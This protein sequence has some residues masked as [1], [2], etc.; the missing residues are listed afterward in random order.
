MCVMEMNGP[1][2]H[3]TAHPA[4]RMLGWREF[5]PHFHCPMTFDQ[6]RCSLV[7]VWHQDTRVR[8]RILALHLILLYVL[9]LR[10]YLALQLLQWG[11]WY[12]V[13]PEGAATVFLSK[14]FVHSLGG[15]N[16][17]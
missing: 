11:H 15:T 16:V 9:L 8:G 7:L 13:V 2:K 12:L 4:S 1:S 14:S 17:I 3:K 5:Q 10:S 6:V